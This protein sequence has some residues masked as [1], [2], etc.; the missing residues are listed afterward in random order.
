L[1]TR[2]IEVIET[3]W[4]WVCREVIDRIIRWIEVILEYVYYILTWVCWVIDWVF[5]LPELLFCL[6]GVRPPKFIRVC[7][8]VLTD[9]RGVPALPLDQAN[10][11]MQDAA[12]IFRQCNIRLVINR[13]ELVAREE[14]LDTTTCEF[15]GMFSGFFQWFSERAA[16]DCVTVY[17]VRDIV[18]ASGCAYP[19][20]Q[21]VTV[22]AQARGCTVVQEI[23]HLADLWGHSDTPGNVM[24]NPCG[25]DL[26]RAQCCMIRTS[27]FATM[28]PTL[29]LTRLTAAEDLATTVDPLENP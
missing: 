10:T 16:P 11:I 14:F 23:G 24:A 17:F 3:V 28:F 13:T 2:L 29:A 19:G 27:R 4:E 22:D 6:I 25:D 18:G 21:W 12:R 9:R 15:S 5:R 8:V 1:V 7:V 26:T 20:A